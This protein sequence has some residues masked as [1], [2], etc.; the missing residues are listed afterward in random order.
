MAARDDTGSVRTAGPAD[1]LA[2]EL[3]A[4]Q[5][6]SGRSLKQL[7]AS[8]HVSDSSLSRY[9]AGRAVAPWSVVAKLAGLA[10]A[11]P[12]ELRPVWEQAWQ[13]RR[14][15]NRASEDKPRGRRW[16]MPSRTVIAVVVTAI[17][18][19]G[20]G[21]L[22]GATM[23]SRYLPRP[24]PA[25]QDDACRTWAWPA[26]DGQDVLPPAHPLGRDHTPTVMLMTGTVAG[27]QMAWARI[28]NAHYGDRVWLDWSANGGM[29]W[30]QCGPFPVTTATGVTKAAGLDP[31]LVFRACGDTPIPAAG[32]TRNACTL[33]W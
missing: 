13:G 11:D 26:G 30:M 25:A 20:L 10:G 4:L 22:V 18:A 8:V 33:Y 1:R 9:L 7:E 5:A 29:T 31:S 15:A 28:T 14:S 27:R 6:A 21:V 3:R 32:A 23:F 19:G 24:A 2:A 12:D 17:V 16:P